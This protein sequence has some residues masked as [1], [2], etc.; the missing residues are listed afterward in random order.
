M[1]R[2]PTATFPS[3]CPDRKLDYLFLSRDLTAQSAE[4]LPIIASDHRPYFTA[5]LV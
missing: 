3:D 5:L 2:G 4:I 1:M